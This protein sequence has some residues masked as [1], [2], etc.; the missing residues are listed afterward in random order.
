MNLNDLLRRKSIDPEQV[1]V[2]RH[3]P[4]EHQLNK[5]LPWLAADRPDL[6]NM[7]QRCQ[8]EKVEQVMLRMLGRGYIASFIGREAGKALFVGL[9]S[10][11]SSKPLSYDEY[12]AMP[13]NR[14]LKALGMTGYSDGAR[15]SIHLFDLG[16]TEFY[17]EWAGK[18]IVGWPP[19]ERSWWRR[20]HRN[21]LP[22]LAVLEESQLHAAMPEWDAIDLGWEE[23]RVLPTR[24]KAALKEW[25]GI[26]YIFDTLDGKAYVGSACGRDNIL[27]R[28]LQY[29]A[30]GHGG[31]QLL[32][33]RDPRNFRLTILQRLSPDIDPAAVIR[34]EGSWKE[35]LHTRQPYGLNEN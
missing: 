3:H 23:L 12:W 16:L 21:E 6:F 22:I 33:R 11:G 35:R 2:L 31:N 27:G 8:R 19:P 25:R 26:Y 18:M 34:I 24:W 9:Y 4:Q 28:W 20:A 30:R 29:A 13:A 32:R 15:S 5:V 17:S 1:L 14:E 7:Y 10:I